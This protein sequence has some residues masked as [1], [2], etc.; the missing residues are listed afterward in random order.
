MNTI[1]ERPLSP[2]DT[3][4][5]LAGYKADIMINPNMQNAKSAINIIATNRGTGLLVDSIKGRKNEKTF[6]LYPCSH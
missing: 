6:S 3:A 5:S 2:T 4:I 1:K